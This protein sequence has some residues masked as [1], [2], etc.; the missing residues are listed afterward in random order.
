MIQD[1]APA[2]RWVKGAMTEVT[3]GTRV[4]ER[5]AARLGPAAA[6]VLPFWL[7]TSRLRSNFVAAEPPRT[8]DRDQQHTG[9]ICI[10][11]ASQQWRYQLLSPTETRLVSSNPDARDRDAVLSERAN[12]AFQTRWARATRQ[13][14]LVPIGARHQ[15]PRGEPACLGSTAR[16]TRRAA[17]RASAMTGEKVAKLVIIPEQ[18]G[19]LHQFQ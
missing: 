13:A 8:E 19:R 4:A 17:A 14:H 3:I 9:K 2:C 10:V 5:K 1:P 15:P 6:G 12:L 18:T 16:R 11:L 7:S